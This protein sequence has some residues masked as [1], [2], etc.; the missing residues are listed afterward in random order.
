MAPPYQPVQCYQYR[1]ASGWGQSETHLV[2]EATVSLT[3]NGQ[4][5][6]SFSCTPTHLDAL[7]AG[8]LY[9]EG[10]I[11]GRE[12]IALINICRQGVNIDVWL[13]KQV[14]RPVSWRRTSGCTGGL[15]TVG[16]S[17][18]PPVLD[19]QRI[20]PE[21][22]L[23][24]MGLLLQ[25]QEMYR[26]TGGI[27]TSILTDGQ[28]TRVKAEDIGRHNTIDKLA[29]HV[30]LD[31]LH[32]HPLILVTTGR[33]SSEMLQKSARLGAAAVISRTSPTSQ[34][35]AM[36]DQLGITLVGYARRDAFTVYAHAERLAAIPT[37]APA[38]QPG[39]TPPTC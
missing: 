2:I 14:D 13:K 7:A 4:E 31:S 39:G 8:F 17:K 12:E 26:E 5:W 18:T 32:I 38:L 19:G 1:S 34:S 25:A 6:L 15:T 27:H 16:Q 35:V 33:V 22:L 11:Q 9:N 37:C 30:L 3:V 36:A 24:C 28:V 23:H 20:A 21:T 10:I 29:G